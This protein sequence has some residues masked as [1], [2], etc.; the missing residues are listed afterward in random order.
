MGSCINSSRACYGPFHTRDSTSSCGHDNPPP[1]VGAERSA[2]RCDLHSRGRFA[3]TGRKLRGDAPSN[4]PTRREPWLI[5]ASHPA[6]PECQRPRDLN[7]IREGHTPKSTKIR[8]SSRA[9]LPLFENFS[10]TGSFV[11][12]PPRFPGTRVPKFR[13]T[14]MVPTRGCR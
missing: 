5:C 6:L 11:F 1:C 12:F 4:S 14:P 9:E 10:K 13:A 7:R 2:A 3:A 8:G